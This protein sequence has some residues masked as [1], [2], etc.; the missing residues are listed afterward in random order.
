MHGPLG[1]TFHPEDQTDPIRTSQ[2]M[3][4]LLTLLLTS[5]RSK[6]EDWASMGYPAVRDQGALELQRISRGVQ[7]E[8]LAISSGEGTNSA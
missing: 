4:D 8:W 2:H 7:F 3:T 1:S 5:L 6:E